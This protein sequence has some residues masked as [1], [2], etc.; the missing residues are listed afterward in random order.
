M[1]FFLDT[2]DIEQIKDLNDLGLVDGIT[3]NPSIIAKS[4]LDFLSTIKDICEI[5][6]G[7]VSAEVL[8]TDFKGMIAEARELLKIGK[9]IT[10]KVPLT[11][12]GLK[13]CKLLS[14]EGHKVNVTLCFSAAQALL[15]AKA[16][17]SY[18]SPFIGRLDDI[19]EDG[20][21][22]IQEICTMLKNYPELKTKVLVASVRSVKHVIEAAKIGADVA[23]IPPSIVKEMV[24]H[25]LT[26][27][28]LKIF[29]EDWKKYSEGK[30]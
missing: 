26:D 28:G 4:G 27:R 25:P 30:K 29:L 1:Q 23:T 3:T 5:V 2:C 14:S 20:L 15:A 9:Q 18:V 19:G 11:L 8:S 17:A 21:Q 16:G 6:K 7:S 24:A 22:L 12:D 10:I 13:A